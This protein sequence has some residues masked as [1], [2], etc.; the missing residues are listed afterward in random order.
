MQLE[1]NSDC[2]YLKLMFSKLIL[3]TLL[4][5]VLLCDLM[6]AFA[7]FSKYWLNLIRYSTLKSS[8][9][10]FSQNL[11]ETLYAPVAIYIS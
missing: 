10:M 5:N 8:S 3:E 1:Q 4:K 9:Y 2:S 11:I 6:T 7:R